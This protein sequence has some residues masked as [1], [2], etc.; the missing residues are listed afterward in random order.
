MHLFF[1]NLDNIGL[2]ERFDVILYKYRILVFCISEAPMKKKIN[3]ISAMRNSGS[4]KNDLYTRYKP[5]FEKILPLND[6]RHDS[7]EDN[8]FYIPDKEFDEELNYILNDTNDTISVVIGYAGIGKSTSLRHYFG[9]ENSSLKLQNNNHTVIF[10]AIFNGFLAEKDDNF[11]DLSIDEMDVAKKIKDDLSLRIDSVCS[12]LEENFD[13]LKEKFDSEIGQLE[14][15]T[16]LKETNPKV[17]EHLPYKKRKY[18]NKKEEKLKKLEYA[19]QKEP[20]ICSA[21]KLK[22]YL[23]SKICKS[24]KIIVIVDDIEPLPY[25]LQVQLVMQYA[26]FFECMKNT[27]SSIIEKEY[28]VNILISLRPHTFRILK[29]YRAFKAF[30]ITRE[31]FK[32]NMVDMAELFRRKIE[33]YSK[34]IPHENQEKWDE[35]CRIIDILSNKFNSRYANMIKNLSLWNTRDAILTYKTVLEDRVWIQRNMDKTSG[36]SINEEHYVFNN[37]TVLRAIACKH[38]YVYKHQNSIIPNILYNTKDKNYC[39]LILCVFSLFCASEEDEESYVY[40]TNSKSF[41]EIIDCFK[42]AF[43]RYK[44]I[45]KDAEEVLFYLFKEKILRKSIN[46]S[47]KIETLDKEESLSINSLLYLSPKGYEIWRMA[48]SDSVYMELCREDYYRDYENKNIC[49]ECSFELMQSGE[50]VKIFC[51][52]FS[53]LMEILEEER[54]YILYA[55]DNNTLDIYKNYFGDN[56]ISQQFYFGI[57]RSIEFSGNINND[58]IIEKINESKEII[59]KIESIL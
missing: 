2:H 19:Y 31:I 51:D 21:T 26:R 42:D 28:I 34:E 8:I 58:I 55:S 7:T 39:F 54:K 45:I 5:A 59:H 25:E 30:Y 17:L 41:G 9:F 32:K 11:T 4:V 14:F 44:D 35:A 24:N 12:F 57:H 13:G 36:F 10:P 43:P 20:F 56:V 47:D 48:A 6:T 3:E 1:L 27:S 18:L 33:F 16:Y 29:E 38:K 46:D 23:G 50:Q 15:Y 40:G 49:M 52:L 37:I 22:Y 53:L